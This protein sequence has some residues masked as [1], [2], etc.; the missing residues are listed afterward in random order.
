[1]GIL[2]NSAD[3]TGTYEISQ[4]GFS[5]LDDYIA[6]FERTYLN[7]ILGY[8]LATLFIASLTNQVPTTPIYQTIFNSMIYRYCNIEFESEGLKSILLNF[9]FFEYMRNEKTSPNANGMIEAQNEVSAP[10]FVGNLYNKYNDA[11]KSMST[12]QLYIHDNSA[13]YPTYNGQNIKFIS[14]NF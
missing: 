11:V 1:M 3:F 12:I 14:P 10:A 8:D 6:R 9:I 7:R 2:V 4:T 5:K 13:D